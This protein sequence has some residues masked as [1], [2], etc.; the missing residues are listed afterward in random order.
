MLSRLVLFCSL[1]YN[2]LGIERKKYICPGLLTSL[3][4]IYVRL[5]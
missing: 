5:L 2:F 3:Y 4:Y 1:L